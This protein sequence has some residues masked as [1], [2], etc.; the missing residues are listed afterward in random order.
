VSNDSSGKRQ[1]DIISTKNL[2][3]SL[4]MR[5]AG[6]VLITLLSMLLSTTLWASAPA[7][8]APVSPYLDLKP[9]FVVN[10]GGVGQLRYLKTDISLRLEGSPEEQTQ[11]RHHV[12]YVRHMIVMR[13]SRATEE[14]L[15][16]TEG[17]ELLRLEVLEEIRAML[18][19]EQ[20]KHVVSD[21]LF[22]SFIVQR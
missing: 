4:G 16:S 11:M 9:A 17:R 15:A 20:G 12:P 14:E 7:S 18:V 10:Y 3:R 21:L 5:L 2:S 19:K 8:D 6:L 13:L 22:N 1:A